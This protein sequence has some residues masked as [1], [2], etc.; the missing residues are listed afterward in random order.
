MAVEN[1]TGTARS[2]FPLSTTQRQMT[3]DAVGTTTVCYTVEVSAA[4]SDTSTYHMGRLPSAARLMPQSMIGFDDLA[5]TGAPT[6]DVGTFNVAG[7][8][9]D[10]V[11]SINDGLTPAT[12]SNG[13]FLIKD[14]AKWG[15]RMWEIAGASSDP[16]GFIDIYVTMD[17]AD[18]NTGGTL[19]VSLVYTLD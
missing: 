14:V 5:S 18:T 13:T 19:S 1:L 11:D 9:A 10:D 7:G 8:T 16:G 4:A 17:D 12:A 6:L 2:V 15:Q 3:T